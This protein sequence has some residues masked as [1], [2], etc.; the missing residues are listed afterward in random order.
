MML[1]QGKNRRT[2][3]KQKLV[4]DERLMR[5]WRAWHREQ[6]KEALAGVHRDV[7]SQLVAQLKDLRAARGL[8][9]FIAA[10][11]WTVIDADTRLVALHEINTAICALRERMGQEPLDDA[12]PGQPLRAY[13]IIREIIN[14]VSRKS[15]E[16]SPVGMTGKTVDEGVSH[17]K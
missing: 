7:M 2:A 12:L 9:D 1:R 6:L 4:D 16:A 3:Q 8:V 10:Q 13:Q 5:N 17:G 15:G 14:P 11:D